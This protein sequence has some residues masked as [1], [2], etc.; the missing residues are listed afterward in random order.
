MTVP[1]EIVFQG[2]APS[3]AIERRIKT[4]VHKLER[5]HQRITACR[6]VVEAPHRR[7][8]KGNLFQIRVHMTVPGHGDLVANQNHGDKHEHEDAYV[9][10]RDSFAATRRQLQDFV[11]VH[12]GKVKSHGNHDAADEAVSV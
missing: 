12:Q 5:Y 10:I 7:H 11:R 6:V 9:A 4:E 8:S 2:I 1:L 3:E